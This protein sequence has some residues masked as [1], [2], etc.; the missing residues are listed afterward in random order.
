MKTNEQ[1]AL[2]MV[3]KMGVKSVAMVVT[4]TLFSIWFAHRI[5]APQE[6]IWIYPIAFLTCFIGI[7]IVRGNMAND[8]LRGFYGMVRHR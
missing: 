4:I 3:Q 8:G 5:D 1:L 7:A 2:R 6:T